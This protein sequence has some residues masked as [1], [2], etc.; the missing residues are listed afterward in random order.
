M[1]PDRGRGIFA[2]RDIPKGQTIWKEKPLVAAWH[3]VR[4][5]PGTCCY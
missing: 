4:S 1:T 2:T 5:V 3:S